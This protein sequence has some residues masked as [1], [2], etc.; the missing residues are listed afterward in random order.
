MEAYDYAAA[1]S[2]IEIFFWNALADNYLEMAKQRLYEGTDQERAG[3]LFA[4][5]HA[6]LAVLKLFAP[7]LPYVTERIYRGLF[8][9]SDGAPSIHRARW[10]EPDPRLEDEEAERFGEVL[11]EI[12]TA[13][14]RYKSEQS[15]S[16]GTKIARLYLAPADFAALGERLRAAKG[17]LASVTRAQEIEVVEGLPEGVEAVVSG[18]AVVV[19]LVR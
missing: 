8:A 1:K 4:L 14:R 11:V 9:G 16:L 18:G 12:A 15:L 3:A 6:L 19:G 2:E 17:D 5:Y 7:F 10:P 13:V